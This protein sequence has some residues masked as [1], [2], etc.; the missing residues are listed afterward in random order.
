MLDENSNMFTFSINSFNFPTV[1]LVRIRIPMPTSQ[2]LL[3][4]THFGWKEG[5][6]MC[7]SYSGEWSGVL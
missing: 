4:F 6:K 5:L 7:Q 1:V 3:N 2:S